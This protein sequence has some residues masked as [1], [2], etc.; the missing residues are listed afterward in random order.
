MSVKKPTG[1]TISRNGNKVK[2]SWKKPEKYNKQQIK[3]S[4]KNKNGKASWSSTH[5]ISGSDTS[6]TKD[7]AIPSGAKFI[8]VAVRG[9]KKVKSKQKYSAWYTEKVTLHAPKNPGVSAAFSDSADN[10]T[11]FS[12]SIPANAQDFYPYTSFVWESILVK[13][14]ASGASAYANYF[15]TSQPGWLTGT[16]TLTSFSRPITEP[17]GAHAPAS[18]EGSWTRIFRARASGPVGKSSW[19]YASHRYAD[20]NASTVTAATY[21]AKGKTVS[22]TW[23]EHKAGGKQPVDEA[24]VE[25]AIVTPNGTAFPEDGSWTD[26]P[27]I[28]PKDGSNNQRFQVGPIGADKALFVRI[29]DTHDRSSVSSDPYL[30]TNGF[31]TLSEPEDITVTVSDKTLVS[32]TNKSANEAS[33]LVIREQNSEG[34]WDAA[35]IPAGESSVVIDNT[36]ATIGVYAAVGS[37]AVTYEEAEVTSEDYTPGYYYVINDGEY[38]LATGTY[39]A[40]E[41]YYIISGSIAVNAK[42]KS[43]VVWYAAPVAPQISATATETPGTIRVDWN[44]TTADA[45][46]LSW[47][48]YANAW[49]SSAK[50]STEEIS[51]IERPSYDLA[52]LETGVVWYIRARFKNGDSFGPYS[53]TA[54]VNLQSAP[55]IPNMIVSD[56][57]IT[58]DG[59]V[60]ASWGYVTTDGTPQ[61]AAVVCLAEVT[62]SGQIIY[63]DEI[64]RTT[65][66]QQVTL[67]ASDISDTP[68][69]YYLCVQ[70]TSGSGILSDGW[71]EPVSVTI[72]DP[73]EVHITNTNFQSYIDPD[74]GAEYLVLTEMPI[75]FDLDSDATV[76][77]ERAE[78][79]FLDRPDETQT[80]GYQGDTI[81]IGSGSGTVT[82]T[83]DDVIGYLDDGASYNLIAQVSDDLGQHGEA[84]INF[85]VLWAEQATIPAATAYYDLTQGVEVITIDEPTEG[86][87]YDIYRLSAD[88]PELIYTGLT[89]ADG[90]IVDPF[91]AIG[92]GYR[93]VE[94]T[95]NGDY[96]TAANELAMTDI[97]AGFT[98]LHGLIDFNGYTLEIAH[99]IEFDNT[100]KKDFETTKYLG[101]AITGDWLPGTEKTTSLSAAVLVT[102]EDTITT[103]R[104]LAVYPGP[105]N[106]RLLDGSDFKANIDVK[107]KYSYSNAGKITTQDLDITRIDPGA[108]DGVLLSVWEES[109]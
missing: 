43:P 52:D 31:G 81:Y 103:L 87:T 26:G 104:R 33:F 9:G 82:I 6:Y 47:S 88:K 50:P 85:S 91:P 41:T 25:Y 12:V 56:P 44:W 75:V 62:D 70:V 64:A 17:E 22:V 58:Q 16:S 100:W 83:N 19:I 36:S 101:G 30:V 97:D 80:G 63:G 106:V 94:L 32:A 98:A 90:P 27:K 77:V 60:T 74:T 59:Q 95:A 35:I 4:W 93:I 68:G 46:E 24:V 11:T 5:T 53:E 38:I 10:R 78:D 23:T 18:I 67:E 79:Y 102:D 28:I 89:A 13:G 49:N 7:G 29:T 65:T 92:G 14:A 73:I 40:N 3:W 48:D 39:D 108:L 8:Y 107:D 86:H 1:L 20:P 55:A 34:T 84:V 99:N 15:K 57:V 76:I 105:C 109:E 69:T 72:A 37:Y 51:Q 66:A 21:D 96:I 61:A 45:V 42:A 2:F 71:S 54:I